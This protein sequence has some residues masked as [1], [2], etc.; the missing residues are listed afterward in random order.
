[1]HGT[2]RDPAK[3]FFKRICTKYGDNNIPTLRAR[4]GAPDRGA[5]NKVETL[6]D[7]WVDV[8]NGRT[9][10]PGDIKS[11]VDKFKDQWETQDL[12]DIDKAITEPEVMAAIGKWKLG[13]ACGPDNI[14]NE[15]YRDDAEQVVPILTRLYNVCLRE[16][17][18]PE[19]FLEAYIFSISKGGDTCNALNYR[20]I[21]LLNTDYKVFTRILAWRVRKHLSKLVHDTQFGFVPGRNIHDT[22]DLLEAAK[23]VARQNGKLSNAQVL[24]LDFAKAYDS[25]DREFLREVL[26]AKG[27]PPKFIGLV[28][29]SH[30]NTSVRFMAN[31]RLSNP[32]QVTSGIRQ[33][34]PLA[35]LFFIIAVDLLYDAISSEEKLRGVELSCGSYRDHINVAGYADDTAIYLES[36]DLQ[37]IALEI[38]NCFSAV[39]GLRLNIKKSVAIRLGAPQQCIL[40]APDIT[41]RDCTAAQYK[42]CK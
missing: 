17:C 37:D 11:Y 31:G 34:C 10:Q 27:F 29:A 42:R 13:K 40:P 3:F 20:P 15:W 30:T 4:E 22:I 23:V 35:P 25:L 2:R 33:G 32:M 14:S 16:D 38:V 5:H 39:S 12:S 21:A 26:K 7:H 18:I 19:S 6:A 41:A 9:D 24:L 28:Q 8:F 1:M 36:S